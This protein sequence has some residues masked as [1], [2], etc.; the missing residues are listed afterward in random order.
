M[1]A[2]AELVPHQAQSQVVPALSY[3]AVLVQVAYLPQSFM[4]SGGL[5]SV[6]IFFSLIQLGKAVRILPF[7]PAN[8]HWRPEHPSG[9]IWRD[10]SQMWSPAVH[11]A[12]VLK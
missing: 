6:L 10:S 4:D 7:G 3:A 8:Q 11:T 12:L 1:Q 2:L 5:R 9:L